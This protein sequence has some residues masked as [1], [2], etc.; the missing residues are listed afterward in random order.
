MHHAHPHAA[1]GRSFDS[2]CARA[3]CAR[4]Q[5]YTVLHASIHLHRTQEPPRSCADDGIVGVPCPHRR[6]AYPDA[7]WK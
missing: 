3:L 6:W 7:G 4:A 2:L 5:M 1:G